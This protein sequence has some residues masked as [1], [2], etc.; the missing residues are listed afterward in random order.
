MFIHLETL[1]HQYENVGIEMDTTV[2]PGDIVHLTNYT[3][4]PILNGAMIE[5]LREGSHAGLWLVHVFKTDQKIMVE[6]K[7][8][9][10]QIMPER[11]HHHHNM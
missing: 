6:T 11:F 5:V 7:H 8:L 9:Q 10:Y 1:H 4:N 3:E 2:T